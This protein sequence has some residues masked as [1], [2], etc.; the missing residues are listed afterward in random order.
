MKQV[1]R[2]KITDNQQSSKQFYSR[3]LYIHFCG[4]VIHWLLMFMHY[5]NCLVKGKCSVP[6][7][8]HRIMITKVSVVASVIEGHCW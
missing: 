8:S 2:V 5:L 1:R 6:Y 4:K 7:I 3:P